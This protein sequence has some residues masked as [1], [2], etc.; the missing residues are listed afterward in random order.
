MARKA[1]LC[2]TT[3]STILNF[4]YAS[5]VRI[6]QY[7][8]AVCGNGKAASTNLLKNRTVNIYVQLARCSGAL[9]IYPTVRTA[10]QVESEVRPSGERLITS[11]SLFTSD[12][13]RKFSQMLILSR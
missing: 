1:A 7:D 6:S 11:L 4:T 10:P 2:H 8:A 12:R 13:V 5:Q 3:D 9:P